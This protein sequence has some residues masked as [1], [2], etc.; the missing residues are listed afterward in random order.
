MVE[1]DMRKL[2]DELP[3]YFLNDLRLKFFVKRKY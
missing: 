1:L 3:H 2:I